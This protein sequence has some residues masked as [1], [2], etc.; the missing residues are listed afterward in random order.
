MRRKLTTKRKRRLLSRAA[1]EAELIRAI[2]A[3]PITPANE[4]AREVLLGA[5]LDLETLVAVDVLEDPELAHDFYILMVRAYLAYL[6]KPAETILGMEI[7]KDDVARRMAEKA[8]RVRQVLRRIAT[9]HPICDPVIEEM[10][11]PTNF[12]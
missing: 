5:L 3:Q 9:G 4:N 11:W 8:A 12:K 1:G 7:D 2:L 10:G 6:E